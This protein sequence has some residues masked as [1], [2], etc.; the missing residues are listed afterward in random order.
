MLSL[1]GGKL[2]QDPGRPPGL[3]NTG[4]NPLKNLMAW[5]S[6]KQ[7]HQPSADNL[8]V[9]SFGQSRYGV[10]PA[11]CS[12]ISYHQVSE[13]CDQTSQSDVRVGTTIKDTQIMSR[14]EGEAP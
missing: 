6:M 1:V 11:A 9:P 12:P 14:G 2:L 8:N 4:R 3:K 10:P 5:E 13:L 7:T